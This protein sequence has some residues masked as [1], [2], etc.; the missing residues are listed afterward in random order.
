MKISE[1]TRWDFKKYPQ[2]GVSKNT[3]GMMGW[4][5]LDLTP[6]KILKRLFLQFEMSKYECFDSHCC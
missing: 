3:L 6:N 1:E 4:N 2:D 5:Q